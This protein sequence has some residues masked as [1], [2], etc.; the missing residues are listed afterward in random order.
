ML[1]SLTCTIIIAVSLCSVSFASGE[2]PDGISKPGDE[3]VIQ[4]SPAQINPGDVFILRVKGVEAPDAPEAR[5]EDTELVFSSC[6]AGCFIAFGAVGLET[7]PGVHAVDVKIGSRELRKSVMVSRGRFGTIHLALPEGKVSLG[8][9]DLT[10]VEREE[11]LLKSLWETRSDRLWEGKFIIPLGHELSTPFGTKRILN[12]KT[13]SVHKGVDIRG[14]EGDRVK[15]SN[16]G[17]VV[18][19]DELFFGGNTVILDHGLGI[20]SVYMHLSGFNV[21]PGDVVSKGEVIGLVGSSGRSSGPHLHFGVRVR[22]MSVNPISLI[23]LTP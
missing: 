3:E 22:D 1:K 19:M 16:R 10:R 4:V 23:H 14:K 18:F 11:N 9:D 20:Y 7:R 8:P 6:G 12:H 5:V 17:R 15:A 13:V 2:E 21:N